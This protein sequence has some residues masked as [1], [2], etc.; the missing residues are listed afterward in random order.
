MNLKKN[1]GKPACSNG[2]IGQYGIAL[3]EAIPQF[4]LMHAAFVVKLRHYDYV[5][6]PTLV[7]FT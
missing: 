5:P 7:T 1:A 2:L 3:D 4:Q 6:Y